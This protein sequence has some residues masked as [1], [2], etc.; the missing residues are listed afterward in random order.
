VESAADAIIITNC[1]GPIQ[2]VNPAFERITGHT[3]KEALGRDIHF[4]DSGQHDQTFFEA[5]RETLRSEGIWRGTVINIKRD[6]T[7]YH[8]ACTIS[9]VLDPQGNTVSYVSIR[10]DVTEELRLKS[11]AEALETM[12]NIGYIFSGICHEIGNPINSIKA[13]LGMLRTNLD[14]FDLATVKAYLERTQL[15]LAAVTELL[16]SIKNFNMFEN[17]RLQRLD[18]VA[19]IKN[20]KELIWDDF[21]QKGITLE[22]KTNSEAKYCYADPR[23]LKQVL[24]NIM[25]NAADA[26]TGRDRPLISISIS[27]ISRM[28][29]LQVSDNGCGMTEEQQ[30]KIFTPF[31]TTKCHGTGLGLINTKKMLAKIDGAIFITSKNNA[32]TVVNITIP[33]DHCGN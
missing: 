27:S 24:L 3:I 32:G 23:S 33:G 2:Y 19:F 18:L 20:F 26:C 8:E 21:T 29:L 14:R 25:S 6:K 16:L 17:P 15:E 31:Y 11:L 9:K 4:L 22:I 30:K 12:N 7:L 10:R 28:V 13:T 5:L 1:K